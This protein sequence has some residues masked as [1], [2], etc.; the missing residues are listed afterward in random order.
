MKITI[1]RE[2]SD[3]CRFVWE[4]RLNCDNYGHRDPTITCER[5]MIETRDTKRHKWRT[6]GPFYSSTTSD[7]WRRNKW[8]PKTSVVVPEDVHQEVIDTVMRALTVTVPDG[9]YERHA[10]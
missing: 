1:A 5:H 10:R 9:H 6:T 2:T 7:D 3:V 8:I 4:F